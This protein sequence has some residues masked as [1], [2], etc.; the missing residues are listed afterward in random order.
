MHLAYVDESITGTKYWIGALVCPDGEIRSLTT[1][2]DEIVAKAARDFEGIFPKSELHG[3][4]LFQGKDD[5]APLA[6]MPRARISIYNQV[7]QAIAE[8]DVYVII[9][10]LDLPGLERRHNGTQKP[11]E[12]V[13]MHLLE[14]ID[15]TASTRSE[16]AIVIADEV[17]KDNE[18]RY[19]QNLWKFQRNFTSGYRS[20]QLKCIVD[21]IHF[22][23]STSSRLLQASDMVTYMWSRMRSRRDFDERAKR[24][25][26]ALWARVQVKV[27]HT[28]CWWP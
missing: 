4:S 7:F 12:V 23:P 5:W 28:R 2:L 27:L 26:E 16:L 22:A 14:R 9:R 18:N 11:H 1:A 24:A 25:N 21:T 17:G 3:Y 15:E 19:R 10:G 20:R 13:L 6:K 8:H